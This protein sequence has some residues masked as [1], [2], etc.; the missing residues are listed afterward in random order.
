MSAASSA[1]KACAPA[2]LQSP[3]SSLVDPAGI[4]VDKSD[5]EQLAMRDVQQEDAE[6]VSAQ[7]SSRCNSQNLSDDGVKVVVNIRG[8]VDVEHRSVNSFVAGEDAKHDALSKSTLQDLEQVAKAITDSDNIHQDQSATFFLQFIEK[9][10]RNRTVTAKAADV[11]TKQYTLLDPAKMTED[12]LMMYAG[13]Y[14]I[15]HLKN[16]FKLLDKYM[17]NKRATPP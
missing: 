16:A 10:L 15:T 4:F 9:E 2:V 11:Y 7:D 6:K 17:I 13:S 14:D 8:S 1:F 5:A 12:S 3:L